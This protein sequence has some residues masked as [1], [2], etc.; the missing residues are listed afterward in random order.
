MKPSNEKGS[1]G[2]ILRFE[3]GWLKFKE[4]KEIVK[5]SWNLEEGSEARNINL[6]LGRCINNLHNWSKNR[7]KG[8]IS[9][10]VKRKEDEILR[11]NLDCPYDEEV[12]IAEAEL[13]ALLDEEEFYWRSR[14]RETWLKNGDKNTK[15][16]HMRAT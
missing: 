14:S 16:F 2:K 13:D 7:L 12:G 1:N 15:W 10:A 5:D 9:A 3:E 11:L 8:S 6:K 4:T